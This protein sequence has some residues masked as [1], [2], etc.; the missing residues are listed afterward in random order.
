LYGEEATRQ[1]QK[2]GEEAAAAYEQEKRD[3]AEGKI[4]EP[5]PKPDKKKKVITKKGPKDKTE[6]AGKKGKAGDKSSGP[7]SG[8]KAGPR[9]RKTKPKEGNAVAPESKKRAKADVKPARQVKEGLNVVLAKAV[10]KTP[11]LGPRDSLENLSDSELQA[12]TAVRIQAVRKSSYCLD[13]Y[14]NCPAPAIESV[15]CCLPILDSRGIRPVGAAM[16]MG[17]PATLSWSLQA[18]IHANGLESDESMTAVQMLAVEYDEG[19]VNEGFRSI[20]QGNVCI[21]GQANKRLLRH[22]RELGGGSA[23]VGCSIGELDCHIGGVPGTCSSRAACIRY[24]GNEF[25]LACLND[26]D[27]VTLNG[28]RI[29]TEMKGLTLLNND[30]CSVGPRVFVFILPNYI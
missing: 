24:T 2:E 28:K 23:P 7:A 20:M 27:I 13:G 17:I 18:F 5:P 12:L 10:S 26:K 19:G 11:I 6:A 1:A 3:I 14:D 30:I 15:R 9:K 22:F 29:T 21:I 8:G 25:Q 16:L 4:P